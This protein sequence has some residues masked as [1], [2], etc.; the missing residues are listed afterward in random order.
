MD[1]DEGEIYL[2]IFQKTL[3]KFQFWEILNVS[4]DR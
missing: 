3:K 2:Q 1:R 4:G